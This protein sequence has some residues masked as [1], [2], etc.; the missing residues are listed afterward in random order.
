MKK[1]S[2]VTGKA[3]KADK[4]VD[5]PAF[6]ND[7]SPNVVYDRGIAFDAKGVPWVFDPKKGTITKAKVISK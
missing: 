1:K 2:A 6:N 3:V 5:I 7:G 4:V